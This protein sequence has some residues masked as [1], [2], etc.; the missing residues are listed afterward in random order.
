METKE[1]P[2]EIP[3]LVMGEGHGMICSSSKKTQE[4]CG[5]TCIPDS[6]EDDLLEEFCIDRI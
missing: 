2:L 6:A 5:P 4:L 3:A 1:E